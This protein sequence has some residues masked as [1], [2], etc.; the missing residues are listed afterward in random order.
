MQTIELLDFAIL[1]DLPYNPNVA[2]CNFHIFPKMKED[3]RGHLYDSNERVGRNFSIVGGS[4]WEANTGE[5]RAQVRN[6]FRVSFINI[7]LLKQKEL[8]F[9][10]FFVQ[11]YKIFQTFGNLL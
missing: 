6:Y 3:F 11:Y 1:P 4:M 10:H 9:R 7:S 8:K 5:Q 2:P